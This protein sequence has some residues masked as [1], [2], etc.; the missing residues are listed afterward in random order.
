M[1]TADGQMR[2]LRKAEAFLRQHDD[3]EIRDVG[4]AWGRWLDVLAD[5]R[6]IPT[7][8]RVRTRGAQSHARR[9]LLAER[10]ASL[11]RLHRQHFGH[12]D[13]AA[14]AKVIHQ[15]LTRYQSDRWPRESDADE[16]PA[17]EPFATFW[18]LLRSEVQIPKGKQLLRI[19]RKAGH[20]ISTLDVPAAAAK[21]RVK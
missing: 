21:S 18:R 12:L 7:T 13:A 6:R 9:R 16:V 17:A 11:C 14:A 1:S 15:R 19:L 4:E 8:L 20:V 10:D 3:P 5:P 2:K